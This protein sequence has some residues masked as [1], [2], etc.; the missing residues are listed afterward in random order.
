VLTESIFGWPGLGQLAVSSISQRD[1][2]LIQGII[3]TFAIA[4]ALVNLIVD[5]LY[6][7]IDPRIRLE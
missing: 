7:W 6:S 1:I 3:L 5:L 4:F 2:P